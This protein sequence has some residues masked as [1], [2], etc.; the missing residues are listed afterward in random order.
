MISLVVINLFVLFWLGASVHFIRNRQKDA[1]GALV[2][3]LV[4]LFFALLFF[5]YLLLIEFM[6]YSGIQC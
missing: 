3:P 5:A 2:A 4:S 1:R 6:I